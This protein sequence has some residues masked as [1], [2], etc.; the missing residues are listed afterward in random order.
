MT[1]AKRL[2]N[3][4]KQQT[5]KINLGQMVGTNQKMVL[6]GMVSL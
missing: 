2:K 3:G 6:S 4:R 5:S 1:F